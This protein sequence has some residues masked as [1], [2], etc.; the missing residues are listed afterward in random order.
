M[1]KNLK[2]KVAL[3]VFLLSLSSYSIATNGFNKGLDLA[4]GS[5]FA[6]KVELKDLPD[7]EKQDAVER[8][9]AV[10]RNR[11]DEIGVAGTMIQ[12][13]GEDQIIVQVP[14]IN[15]EASERIEEILKRQAH[16]EFRL[17]DD[18]PTDTNM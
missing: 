1:S 11:I 9:M 18:D 13:S 10:Y 16:L 2:W 6:I 8:T 5:H 7:A 17:V 3:V 12:R 4:G 14:G 15:T